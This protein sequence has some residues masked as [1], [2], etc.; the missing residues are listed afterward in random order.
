MINILMIYYL[1]FNFC[2]FISFEYAII[3]IKGRKR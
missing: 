1:N 3:Q 2:K